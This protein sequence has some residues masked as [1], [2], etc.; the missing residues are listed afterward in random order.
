MSNALPSSS[1]TYKRLLKQ[2]LPYKGYFLV[3]ILAMI[4]L[5]ATEAGIPAGLKPLLDGTFVDKD[6]SYL[7]WAPLGIVIL[8]S[9]RG[10]FSIISQITFT[11]I[12][13]QLVLDLRQ[14][15]F[16]RL[17]SLP[18]TFYDRNISGK[19]ISKLVY[20]VTQVTQAGTQVLTVLV[21]DTVTVIALV[22]YLFWLDW[23][24]SIFIL[25]LIPIITAVAHLIGKRIRILN[26]QLQ[27]FFGEMTHILEE[28]IKAHKVI[29]IFGGQ[30]YESH[31]FGQTAKN[32]KHHQFKHAVAASIGVP[33]VELAGAIV[34]ALVVYLGTTKTDP[35]SV[36][37]F[38]AFFAALGL[39]FS[40]IKR[41]TKVNDPLQR[42]LAAAESVFEL[43][44]QSS[45]E[46]LG[47][48]AKEIADGEITFKNVTLKYPNTNKNALGPIN[49]TIAPQS[50]VA[51]VGASGSGKTTFANLIPRIYSS[52]TGAICL[53][54][55]D[56]N[57]WSLTSL[58][59]QISYVSQDVVLFN[60]SVANNIAYG[61]AQDQK[62]IEH[63]AQT[64]GATEFIE[65]MP[66]GIDTI[67]GE[68]GVR[69]SGGQR[70][71][72]AIAR[73]IYAN[74]PIL[75]LDEAT[76]AL[77]NKSE[78]IV[79]N[80][81]EQLRTGR[82]TIIIAHRLSTIQSAERILVLNE[83]QIVEDGTHESLLAI[84]GYYANLINNHEFDEE[85]GTS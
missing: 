46:D 45:E 7:F 5:G 38:V 25:V 58:R 49:L 64:A 47:T 70:Q 65:S 43:L 83:G 52:S 8:F 80:A 73:A 35:L 57:T 13:T 36:G 85:T 24:L 9:F 63:A 23:K 1:E 50:T 15:M 61:E 74:T 31:R 18:T 48:F 75:I 11:K 6:P 17:M 21:K 41:L 79:K 76:S 33:I 30:K 77:D 4:L 68:N 66:E 42:G 16:Q 62:D 59:N 28:S 51:L 82:T 53:D 69:L 10:L 67:I 27:L 60:D 72:L 34:L 2:I 40:P 71:R 22:A 29:K 26:R 12:S 56:L 78:A 54:G 37:E 32:I 14:Q 19:L 44:D 39:L 84:N 20:D 81:L 55:I 3:G